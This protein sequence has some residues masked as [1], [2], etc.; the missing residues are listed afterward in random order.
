V[1]AGLPVLIAVGGATADT[2]SYR[3]RLEITPNQT[4]LVYPGN[5]HLYQIG[6]TA[7]DI[8][9]ARTYA[10]SLGGYLAAVNDSAENA[11]IASQLAGGN[12]VWIGLS[13]EITEGTFLWDS[14]E[15]Y[16]YSSWSPGEP[17]DHPSCNGEDYVELTPG[18]GWNDLNTGIN[19]CGN[20]VRL[21]LVEIPASGLAAIVDLGGACGPESL[22]P[23]LYS[24]PHQIGQTADLAVLDA[25]PGDP[26]FVYKSAPPVAPAPV[27]DCVVH[28]DP[29]TTTLV[30]GLI[31]NEYGSVSSAV[32]TPNDPL[33]IGV[34]E[35]WQ[36]QIFPLSGALSYTNALEVTLGN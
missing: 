26:V 28:L 14:G 16:G 35:I 5:G 32:A 15:P 4:G 31:A 23:T 27:V 24:E 10:Q 36:A 20:H 7:V 8:P 34:I 21:P 22:P 11:W 12:P 29:G 18:G 19:P 2:G 33:L 13:D 1:K 6:P 3:L 30:A 17:N 9:A 25:G